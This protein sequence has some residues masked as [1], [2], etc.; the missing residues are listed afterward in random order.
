MSLKTFVKIGKITNLSDARY[1][2]GMMVDILGFNLEE[3]TEGF[4][5]P[6]TFKEITDWVAGVKFAGEFK[7]AHAA[8]IKLASEKYNL[9]YIEVQ[10]Q[11]LLDELSTLDI[12]LIYK[13]VIS[14]EGDVRKIASALNY[15]SEYTDMVIVDCLKPSMFEELH[16]ILSEQHPKVKLIRSYGI[17]KATVPAIANDEYFYGIELEGSP[18][19]RPGFKDYGDVMDILEVL[20]ED[21]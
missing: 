17:S 5:S 15:A 13:L 4:V 3:G 19:D 10:D 14:S 7:N 1:C 18:E 20:E 6:E 11:E 16:K 8:E 12:P 2:A 9:D 21:V